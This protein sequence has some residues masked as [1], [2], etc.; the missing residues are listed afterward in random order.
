MSCYARIFTAVPL[1]VSLV[2]TSVISVLL[3]SVLQIYKPLLSSTQ[4]AT[5]LGGF[6]ASWLFIFS[7]TA[8]SNLETVVLGKEFQ[9]KLFPEVFICLIL[10][11]V[12]AG[13]VHRV[14]VTTWWVVAFK[15]YKVLLNDPTPLSS[16]IFSLI[17][18]YFVNRISQRA[19]DV[20]ATPDSVQM[21]KKKK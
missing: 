18:L 10:S 16:I 5:I 14:C 15:P 12:A 9:A 8:V 17:G 7:L 6:V 20:A 13:M 3:F 1:S 2:I 11:T 21:K 4:S 19:N